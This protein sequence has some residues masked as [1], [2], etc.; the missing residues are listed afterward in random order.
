MLVNSCRE[1]I[2]FHLTCPSHRIPS[3]VE[4]NVVSKDFNIVKCSRLLLADERQTTML[5]S[6][7]VYVFGS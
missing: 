5:E 1:H 2:C 6:M 4:Q 7:V 3:D